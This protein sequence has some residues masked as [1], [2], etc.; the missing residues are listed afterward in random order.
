M[1]RR[2][3]V[4]EVDPGFD[5]KV[6]NAVRKASL[7]NVYRRWYE[8]LGKRKRSGEIIRQVPQSL[9]NQDTLKLYNSVLRDVKISDYGLD[10]KTDVSYAPYA[11]AKFKQKG[12]LAPQGLFTL[13]RDDVSNLELFLLEEYEAVFQDIP[14]DLY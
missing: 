1:A 8:S 7:L 6:I 2:I 5:Q 9:F 13:D 12:S 11:L 10:I 3:A 4:L 14:D